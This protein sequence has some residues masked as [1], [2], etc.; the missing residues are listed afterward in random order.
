MRSA[1]SAG[2]K[3]TAPTTTAGWGDPTPPAVR[4]RSASPRRAPTTLGSGR[5]WTGARATCATHAR[6]STPRPSQTEAEVH[7]V[8]V[9]E[10]GR[11]CRIRGYSRSVLGLD[12]HAEVEA[13]I[14]KLDAQP[15]AA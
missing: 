9:S 8:R 10:A 7:V 13:G 11:S 12:C 15:T 3:T 5:R 4:T 14:L 1:P 2:G 6:R